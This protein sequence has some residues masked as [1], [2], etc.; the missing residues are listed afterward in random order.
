[1]AKELIG[2]T[3]IAMDGKMECKTEACEV[4]MILTKVAGVILVVSI[5][6]FLIFG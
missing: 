6:L 3:G 2:Q 4:S 1:M 5:V